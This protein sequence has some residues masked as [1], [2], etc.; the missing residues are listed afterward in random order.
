[1]CSSRISS[2]M[3]VLDSLTS[4][5]NG[6]FGVAKSRLI[7]EF[8]AGSAKCRIGPLVVIYRAAASHSP[9]RFTR[10]PSK[11]HGGVDLFRRWTAVMRLGSRRVA[12]G[13]SV[14]RQYRAPVESG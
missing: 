12:I 5:A 8:H 11:T 1:M 4:S 7:E 2:A 10:D 3:L 14:G 6:A 9:A 13:R